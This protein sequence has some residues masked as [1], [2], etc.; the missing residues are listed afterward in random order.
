M[1]DDSAIEACGWK[2]EVTLGVTML[3]SAGQKERQHGDSEGGKRKL[4][5]LYPCYFSTS[6]IVFTLWL[7][8]NPGFVR[9]LFFTKSSSLHFTVI[10]RD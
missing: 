8:S 4:D 7:I 6:Q 3:E 10:N 1:P 2:M 5:D 9:Y